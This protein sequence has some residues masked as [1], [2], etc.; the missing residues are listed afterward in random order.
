M[1]LYEIATD[2][3]NFI[4][5]VENGEVPDEAITDTL[6]SIKALLEDKADNIAC[7][8]KNMTAD[9]EAIKAE[10]TRLAERRKQKEATADRLKTYLA[11]MLIKAG[12]T[13][14]ET[15]RNKLSFR[16]S[17]VVTVDNEAEFIEWAMN[18]NR[19]LLTFKAPTISKTAIKKALADGQAIDGV[20]IESKSNL[21]IK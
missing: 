8:I 13:N 4:D 20:R 18:E 6:E 14:L 17:E 2:Y 3:K 5:A 10:E 12:Q 11:D 1:T 7:L 15:A 21:Q 16:K 9:A 19:D